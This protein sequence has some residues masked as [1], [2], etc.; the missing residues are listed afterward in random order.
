MKLLL[1]AIIISVTTAIVPAGENT[2]VD[3]SQTTTVDSTRTAEQFRLLY[4][5]LQE[6]KRE[7]AEDAMKTLAFLIVALGWFITSDKSR[8]FFRRHR[9]ARLSSIFAVCLLA[10]IHLKASLLAYSCSQKQTM[11]LDALRYVDPEYYL[12]YTIKMPTLIT[13]LIQNIVLFGILVVI[14]ISLKHPA[15]EQ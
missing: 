12:M 15:V 14:L 1:V 13:N 9:T 6:T 5:S 8:A 11:M 3:G 10:S 4:Q 7:Y 2:P